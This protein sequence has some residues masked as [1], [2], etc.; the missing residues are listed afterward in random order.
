MAW[1]K[2]ANLYCLKE[3]INTNYILSSSILT[4]CDFYDTDRDTYI[5][6]STEKVDEKDSAKDVIFLP[7]E[8]RK[9][10]SNN[11]CQLISK[12]LFGVIV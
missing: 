2:S 9:K 12:G 10:A 3:E 11:K 7:S 5:G 8:P 6:C 1:K 4:Y